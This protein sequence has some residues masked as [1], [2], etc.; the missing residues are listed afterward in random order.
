MWCCLNG[1]AF[2]VLQNDMVP[3]WTCIAVWPFWIAFAKPD[4]LFLLYLLFFFYFKH[5][6]VTRKE[7]CSLEISCFENKSSYLL[8]VQ[9]SFFSYLCSSLASVSTSLT[10]NLFKPFHISPLKCETPTMYCQNVG[11]HTMQKVRYYIYWLP[12]VL[13]KYLSPFNSGSKEVPCID[14]RQF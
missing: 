9:K 5:K 12:S 1:N 13:S 10:V 6:R 2:C 8:L 11:D 4:K 3:V 7:I 14:F